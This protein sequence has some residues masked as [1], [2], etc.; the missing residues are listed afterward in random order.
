MIIYIFKSKVIYAI[1]SVSLK[2]YAVSFFVE[3][4]A[5][6]SVGGKFRNIGG[7]PVFISALSFLGDSSFFAVY[8][9]AGISV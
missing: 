8:A 9:F 5:V 3:N 6:I 7:T 2:I 1:Y 4:V